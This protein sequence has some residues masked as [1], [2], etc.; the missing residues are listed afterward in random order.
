MSLKIFQP[1]RS[2]EPYVTAIWD[3]E[4]LLD[5]D[6]LAL[7]ILPDTATYLCFLYADPLTTAHKDRIYTTRNGM[8]PKS[9]YPQ[10]KASQTTQFSGLLNLYRTGH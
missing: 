6:N 7:S 9:I 1:S 10:M 5:G 4:N 2:L 3:Y 8:S